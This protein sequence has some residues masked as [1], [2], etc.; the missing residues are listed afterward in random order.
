MA[1]ASRL[2]RKLALAGAQGAIE[3]RRGYGYRLGLLD[4]EPDPAA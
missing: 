4:L 3:N 2:R 1:H